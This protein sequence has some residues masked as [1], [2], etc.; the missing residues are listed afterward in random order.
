MITNPEIEHLEAL[1]QRTEGQKAELVTFRAETLENLNPVEDAE[2]L[3]KFEDRY[4]HYAQTFDSVIEAYRAAIYG[5]QFNHL[6]NALEIQYARAYEG[7]SDTEVF[8]GLGLALRNALTFWQAVTP[9]ASFAA[10]H[11]LLYQSL[12]VDE[13]A[14]NEELRAW[15]RQD[16]S[17]RAL[18]ER[19]STAANELRN[20][21]YDAIAAELNRIA[22]VFD[23]LNRN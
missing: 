4:Q 22:S 10:A 18:V 21:A 17:A 6:R 7:T 16:N 11:K 15:E 3:A 9:P 2:E 5:V 8:R 13:V 23:Q 20:K 1:I 19:K 12:I 14:H